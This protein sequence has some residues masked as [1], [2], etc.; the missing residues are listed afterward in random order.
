MPP[1]PIRS[2]VHPERITTLLAARRQCA[3]PDAAPGDW[4]VQRHSC[5]APAFRL[6]GSTLGP[7]IRANSAPWPGRRAG[8][9][10]QTAEFSDA[11]EACLAN[12]ADCPRRVGLAGGSLWSDSLCSEQASSEPL[13]LCDG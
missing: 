7:P 6:G 13:S 9:T 4:P 10:P 2:Q 3:N 12:V 11:L 5:N 1:W 8:F